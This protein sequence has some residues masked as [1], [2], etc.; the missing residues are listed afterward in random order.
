MFQSILNIIKDKISGGN[1]NNSGWRKDEESQ[2]KLQNRI[3]SGKTI[4]LSNPQSSR[5]QISKED[6]RERGLTKQGS[7]YTADD[8]ADMRVDTTKEVPVAS[9]AVK[10]VKY[11]PKTEE[12]KIKYTS[13]NK[14]YSFPKVPKEVI[15][16]FLDSP[17]K[18]KYLAH[19]IRPKYSSNRR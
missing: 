1:F 10:K 15:E 13:G 19:I 8:I 7:Y 9:T 4:T 17:S 6:L 11:N 5:Y 2:S 16:E 14:E 3:D 12:L 18:G